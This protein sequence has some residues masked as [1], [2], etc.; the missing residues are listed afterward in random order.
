MDMQRL[1][2]WLTV[3]VGLGLAVTPW[4]FHFTTDWVAFMDALAAGIIVALLGLG[5]TYA[6]LGST[7]DHRPSH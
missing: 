7:T 6:A 5:L 3:L 1:F 4:L 2:S